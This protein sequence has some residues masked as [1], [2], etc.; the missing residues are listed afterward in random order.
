MHNRTRV[1]SVSRRVALAFAALLP[2]GVAAQPATP[3]PT[4]LDTVV[5]TANPLGSELLDMVSPVSVLS[6]ERLCAIGLPITA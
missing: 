4:R 1:R 3:G 5:V 6:G 2:A